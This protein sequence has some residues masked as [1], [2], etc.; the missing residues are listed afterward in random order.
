MAW[1]VAPKGFPPDLPQLR[2]IIVL[3][4]DGQNWYQA[5]APA[6]VC[7]WKKG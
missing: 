3:T 1:A 6:D 5:T 7:Y 4:A 2:G